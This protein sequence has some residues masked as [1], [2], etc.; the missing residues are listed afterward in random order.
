MTRQ[1]F[2][3]WWQCSAMLLDGDDEIDL[4]IEVRA[5]TAG[6]AEDVARAEWLDHGYSPDTVKTSRIDSDCADA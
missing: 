6:E 3:P 1:T 2:L 4:D 5:A